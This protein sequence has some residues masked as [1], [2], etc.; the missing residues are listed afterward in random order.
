MSVSKNIIADLNAGEKLTSNNYDVWHRKAQFLLEMQDLLEPLTRELTEAERAN[1]NRNRAIEE[2]KK[3]DRAARI[4]LLSSMSNDVLLR[5]ERYRT[6][7]ELWDAVKLQY[8]DTSTTRL[9]QLTL[10]LDGYKKRPEH[11]MREHILAMSNMISELTQ[12]GHVL[13]DEQQVQAVIR[14]LPRSWEHL[15][16]KLTHNDNILTFD[17]VAR[18]VELEEDRLS[19]EKAEKAAGEAM[20]AASMNSQRKPKK[21]SGSKKGAGGTGVANAKIDKK[22]NKKRG[23]G[24]EKPKGACFNCDQ[25]GHFAR[26][27]TKPKKVL[28]GLSSVSVSVSAG[29]WYDQRAA[30]LPS[31]CDSALYVS[32]CFMLTNNN[33]VWTVDSAATDH[34]AR[35]RAAFVDY[36]RIPAGSKRI[37]MGNNS[38]VL[39]H[40]IGTCELMFRNGHKL[41]LHDVLYMPD[42]RRSLVSV[43]V[44]VKTGLRVVFL[45]NCVELYKNSILLGNGF[46]E[47]NFMILDT[48]DGCSSFSY[49]VFSSNVSS[50]VN[51]NM[52]IWHARLCH[53]GQDRM[54]RLAKVGLLGPLTKVSLPRCE[55]CLAGKATRKPFGKA[56]RATTPLQLIHSDI[57]GPLSVRA[58]HGAYYF[59]TFIDD[60]TRFG[61]VYLIS[62]KSDA[63]GCFQ[64]YLAMVENQQNGLVKALRTD[65]G[66]EYL[67][68]Q[69]KSLCDEKGIVHQLT[70]PY[71]PQ[72]NG[73]AERRNRT[74]LEM[75]RS[76]MAQASLPISYWGD[77]LL[78]ATYVL[79][80]VPS[81]S[82]AATPYELWTG[83]KPNLGCRGERGN[84]SPPQPPEVRTIAEEVA[85][86]VRTSLAPSFSGPQAGPAGRQDWRD[87]QD[88]GPVN[89]HPE[90]AGRWD[91]QR[92]AEPVTDMQT[93]EVFEPRRSEREKVPRRRFEIEG[94]E[95]FMTALD[96][97]V[98]PNEDDKLKRKKAIKA[99]DP[100]EPKNVREALSS[101]KSKE[102]LLAMQEEI[103]SMEKNQVWDL[104][105]LPRGRKAV[106]SK[107]VLKAKR[108]NDGSIERY[109]ARLVAKGFTQVEGVDYE[110]TFSPVVRFASIRLILAIVAVMD[111]ELYQMDVKTA[112]LNG[113]LQEE[114]YMVQP[115]AFVVE[116][117]EHMVCRLR[118]SIY[119]LKQASRQWNLR[120]HQA[121]LSN[122]F[123]VMEEDHCVYVKGSNDCFLIMTLYVDDI[124]LAGNNKSLISSTQ[125]W[126]SSMF[127]MKD[128]GEASYVLGVK[129]TR[130]RTKRF[131][132]LSQETYVKKILERYD[133]DG[134]R[135][136]DTPIDK[137]TSLSSDMGPNT[138][139]ERKKMENVPYSSAVG[140]LM[141]AMLCTRPDICYAVSLVSRFQSNPGFAHWQAVKRILRYL[142]NTSDY[143][144]CYQGRS[145]DLVGYSDAD[146]AGDLD[147]RKSTSGFIFMLGNS[148]ISWASKKQ[149]CVA[150]STMEAEYIACSAAT[151]EAIWLR[152]F[153]KGLGVVKVPNG[154]V[155]IYCDSTA[156]IAFS[157]DPK[158]HGKAKHIDTRYHFVRDRQTHQKIVLKHISTDEMVADPFTKPIARM[159]FLKLIRVMGLMSASGSL[160]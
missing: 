72:Q 70:T 133:M 103:D 159:Q 109:K 153:L 104:V 69:F 7:K 145:L 65:R 66:R 79:N 99:I 101:S 106:G 147:E 35:D 68:D 39:V 131:L 48:I 36:R 14:S 4:T 148:V 139:A 111:L 126:L 123:R 141:Y 157:R 125:A 11:S 38:S 19:A 121:V 90:T 151:Q 50:Y 73:V 45:N 41:V 81:K 75:V 160:T 27:C 152:R 127:D 74:L 85:Q 6:T 3:K 114:I 77:A 129:I 43:L 34:I 95:V 118:R 22:R 108:K 42:V 156:A 8:G 59:I 53:V 119:G 40:G 113:E 30:G 105:D 52:L 58:R 84:K 15:R 47:N 149:T 56:V 154:P 5:F 83:R 9:R 136:V 155:T 138:D 87:F 25:I 64:K 62:H 144:L 128:M 124:L 88:R 20:I 86:Q 12:A 110:E 146:W 32:S 82:V 134:C 115:D 67:S 18:H 29:H 107:W 51:D 112:F 33:P 140:S 16:V 63:L 17:Q 92:T 132:S 117:K 91:D 116:G 137:N 60:Y 24:K 28:S 93:E 97:L 37:Y 10:R 102:W 142:K 44:L 13:S 78:T 100:D 31:A 120:F 96:G 122:G 80:R 23:K 150:L 135:S 143:V 158:Y 1:P 2:F 21:N 55:G 54:T 98:I 61:H 26:D 57:C 49:D 130:D 94:G 46:F 89:L 76:M 71:T